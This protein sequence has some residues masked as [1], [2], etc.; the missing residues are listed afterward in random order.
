MNTR[1]LFRIVLSIVSWTI[2]AAVAVTGVWAFV[3]TWQRV[4]EPAPEMLQG[5]IEATEIDVSSKI[6]GRIG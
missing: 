1:H 5:Q 6:P 3:R 4:A 2:L